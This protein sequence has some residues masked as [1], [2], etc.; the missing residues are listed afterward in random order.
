MAER[1]PP[2]AA[3]ARCEPLFTCPVI[4][5]CLIIASLLACPSLSPSRRDV[6]VLTVSKKTDVKTTWYAGRF[7]YEELMRAGIKVYEYTPTMLH[8]KTLVVD[9]MWS[10]VG[11]MNFDNRS[12]VFN[13]ESNIASLD[14]G[15][16]STLDSLFM[17][18]LRYSKEIK[19]AEFEQRSWTEKL[20]E[21]GANAFQRVL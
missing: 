10:S 5:S 4:C 18:D 20:L 12:L 3:R 17:A 1:A 16:G 15:V 2:R 19:L 11:S 14:E 13:N 9:G 6:R 7:R 21:W 8:S